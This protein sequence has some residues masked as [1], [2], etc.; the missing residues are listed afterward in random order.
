MI[1]GQ[2]IKQS[3]ANYIVTWPVR[4]L[5][6]VASFTVFLGQF[7]YL[8]YYGISHTDE[9]NRYILA[10]SLAISIP[11]IIY[12]MRRGYLKA[13]RYYKVPQLK[14]PKEYIVELLE[15]FADIPSILLTVV[16]ILLLKNIGKTFDFEYSP[17]DRRYLKHIAKLV[18]SA[19]FYDL[20]RGFMW[21][22]KV[23]PWRLNS[24]ID[25][26]YCC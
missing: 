20:E 3:L 19:F 17:V 8:I 21:Y 7:G 24:S 6:L 9:T 15:L 26:Q 23:F 18:S 25:D 11:G 16:N 14:S 5:F 13:L 2:W 4:L 12:L 10:A 22:L 1:F